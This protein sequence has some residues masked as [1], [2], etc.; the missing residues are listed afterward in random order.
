M[1]AQVLIILALA[2]LTKTITSECIFKNC[3]SCPNPDECAQCLPSFYLTPQKLCAPCDFICTECSASRKCSK[4]ITG[5]YLDDDKLCKPCSGGNCIE[6]NYK[7]VCT[8]CKDG[9]YLQNDVCQ[10]CGWYCTKCITGAECL[11]CD[12][13]GGTYLKPS[14]SCEW[15]TYT[16]GS[17][18]ALCD[19]QKCLACKDPKYFVNP[20]SGRC[21]SCSGKFSSLCQSCTASGC[22]R[23][24]EPNLYYVDSSDGMCKPCTNIAKCLECSSK[25]RCILC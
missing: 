13:N 23:C 3:V 24:Q 5:F 25:V 22:T 16:Y 9:F 14:K 2:A 15:C 10:S 17:D 20:S 18:C 6:C 8:K 12:S 19:S 7:N 11:E 21:E 4:C 1:R